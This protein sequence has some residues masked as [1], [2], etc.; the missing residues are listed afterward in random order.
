VNSKAGEAALFLGLWVMAAALPGQAAPPS[1]E[2]LDALLDGVVRVRTLA[3]L[4]L[5]EQGEVV[6]TYEYGSGALLAGGFVLTA[7]HTLRDWDRLEPRDRE[8]S[9]LTRTSSGYF[10]VEVV[11]TNLRRD[12]AVLRV[13]PRALRGARP[14]AVAPE[15]P[16]AGERA[17]ALGIRAAAAPELFEA[18]ILNGVTLD[19]RNRML[20]LGG[21]AVAR[22]GPWLGISQK[23]LPGYSGGPI[24]NGTGALVGII[25]GAPFVDDA[26]S[27]F[28]YGVRLE[29]FCTFCTILEI[30][31]G[32]CEWEFH[33]EDRAVRPAG[34]DA[35][36][37]ERLSFLPAPESAT[38]VLPALSAATGSAAC[39]TFES[40]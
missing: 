30:L 10:P 17:V 8:V 4:R 31:E 15:A 12:I 1:L 22:G 16:R 38:A 3:G 18:G 14:L 5:G 6:A 27:E 13:N 28:S 34:I 19:V 23:I 36:R 40:L 35:V 29:A 37:G 20:E 39:A 7:L 2:P 26:W 25:L 32:R 24:L 33:A 9:I 11:A 21:E